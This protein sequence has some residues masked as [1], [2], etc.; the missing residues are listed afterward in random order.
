MAAPTEIA[1][2]SAMRRACAEARQWLGATSPNPPVGAAIM[3]SNGHIL[4]VAA[5]RR[6]GGPHAETEVIDLCRTQNKLE[7]A[8]TLCVTLEPCNHHGRTP[9]CTDMIIASG[10][11]HVVIGARDHNPHVKG[12]GIERLQQAG[13]NVTSGIDE[14]ECQQLIHAFAQTT[15]NGQPWITIKRAISSNGSMIPPTGEKT[16]TSLASLKL[17]HRMRKKADAII[18][19][20]G[21]ILTDNP[22]F[23]VRHVKDHTDKRRWLAILDR[24]GRVPETYIAAARGRGLDTLIYKDIKAAVIDLMARGAQ[25]ILVEAGPTL[26][27]A[28]LDSHLWTM[29]VTIHQAN[30]DSVNVDFNTHGALPFATDHFNWDAFLP[31]E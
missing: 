25:D 10:I 16:F 23:T 29:S 24:R 2:L 1:L 30:S 26:S 21:T 17:A 13:I 31:P 4:A 7:Q 11:K 18:T 9:P 27:Q 28:M 3:D 8:H 22:L 19:G 20:S 14:E 12:G 15:Q 6:A 5:H